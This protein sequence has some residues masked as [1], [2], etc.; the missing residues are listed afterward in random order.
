MAI[1]II[2]ITA[3]VGEIVEILTVGLEFEVVPNTPLRVS[4]IVYCR[5]GYNKGH[6]GDYPSYK[7]EFE[8][9]KIKLIIP[10]KNAGMVVV[11]VQEKVKLHELPDPPVEFPTYQDPLMTDDT[12]TLT[13][14][15]ENDITAQEPPVDITD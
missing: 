2:Q 8:E 10:E 11:E 7:V 3:S 13:N 1:N 4:K 6:Q 5:K 12:P 14:L 9:A 15:V